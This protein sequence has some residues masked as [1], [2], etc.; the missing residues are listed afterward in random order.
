MLRELCCLHLLLR[1][2]PAVVGS[3]G[4]CILFCLVDATIQSKFC[5]ADTLMLISYGYV[6]QPTPAFNT[7]LCK[8]KNIK[9]PNS[10]HP[11]C[12]CVPKMFLQISVAKSLAKRSYKKSNSISLEFL[13]I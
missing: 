9:E 3:V 10:K 12:V 2:G 6:K 7:M 13:Q 11:V 4:I 8:K 1:P 5:V